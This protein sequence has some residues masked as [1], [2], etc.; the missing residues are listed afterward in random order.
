MKVATTSKKSTTLRAFRAQGN[1][2]FEIYRCELYYLFISL[3]RVNHKI[4]GKKCVFEIFSL[5]LLI[6]QIEMPKGE[7]STEHKTQRGK[8]DLYQKNNGHS[9][10]RNRQMFSNVPETRKIFELGVLLWICDGELKKLPLVS[11]NS[12]V[13]CWKVYWDIRQ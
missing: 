13:L 6:W 8:L 12:R 2:H 11:F 9:T 1:L 7:I 4:V 10:N 5:V 3:H